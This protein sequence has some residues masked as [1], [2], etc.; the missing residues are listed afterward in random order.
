MTKRMSAL[1]PPVLPPLSA[2]GA[3]A[4]YTIT[5][6]PASRHS[7]AVS[8]ALCSMG[9]RSGAREV[10]SRVRSTRPGVA[11]TEAILRPSRKLAE[12]LPVR[13]D[14]GVADGPQ[15]HARTNRLNCSPRA[16]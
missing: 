13:Q 12:Y 5:A 16:S 10:D 2:A 4:L 3:E 1:A 6:P 11:A 14:T 7:V 9:R 15:A 8:S